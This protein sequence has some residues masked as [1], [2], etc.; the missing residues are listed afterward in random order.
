LLEAAF[1]AS[2]ADVV[3]E[4]VWPQL[5]ANECRL[6]RLILGGNLLVR[7]VGGRAS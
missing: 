7:P 4:S 5:V 3:L 2:N 6:L 1:L